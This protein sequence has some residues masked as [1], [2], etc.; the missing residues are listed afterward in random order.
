M[1]EA[2]RSWTKGADVNRYNNYGGT[3]LYISSRNGH[4]EAVKL[5]LSRGA[6]VNRANNGGN[7]PLTTASRAGAAT[8]PSSSSSRMPT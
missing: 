4:Q 8:V 5:L 1:N 2:G 7:A 3:P 6:K